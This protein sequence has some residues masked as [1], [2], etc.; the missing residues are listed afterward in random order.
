MVRYAGI[1]IITLA[2][3]AGLTGQEP[4][5]AA[6]IAAAES[7]R[8]ANVREVRSVREYVVRNPRW[9]TDAM[10]HAT[11]ITSADGSK[12]YEIIRT[13]A[14]GLRKKILLRILDGEVQAAATK[15][16]DGNVNAENYEIRPNSA[17]ATAQ[18]CRS[19][20]LAPKKRTRFTLEGHA[21]VDMSDMAI[22]RMEGRTAKRISFLVGRAYVVQEFRKIGEFWYS[23]GSRSTADVKFFGR[24]EL[25]ITY[26]DYTITSRTG[27]VTT[28][29]SR[30]GRANGQ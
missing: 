20:T 5:L 19:V 29:N 21:C 1:I 28:A 16:R 17:N 14:E 12:R 22:V 10:M 2:I 25:V 26:S 3:H 11:M 6:Q 4:D 15:D 27:T 23:S 18:P 30:P 13:N 9:Q 24:T 8:D 7:R